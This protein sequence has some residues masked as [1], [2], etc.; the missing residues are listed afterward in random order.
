M[1]CSPAI[2]LKLESAL[3]PISFD[4]QRDILPDSSLLYPAYAKD[5]SSSCRLLPLRA[6][7]CF[8]QLQ[9][10]AGV[11]FQADGPP[12]TMTLSASWLQAPLLSGCCCLCAMSSSSKSPP[13]VSKCLVGD[14]CLH[15]FVLVATPLWNQLFRSGKTSNSSPVFYHFFLSSN[16]RLLSPSMPLIKALQRCDTFFSWLLILVFIVL[17]SHTPMSGTWSIYLFPFSHS[18]IQIYLPQDHSILVACLL[19]DCFLTRSS[20]ESW[21]QCVSEDLFSCSAASGCVALGNSVP[22]AVTQFP[23]W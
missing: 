21:S 8:W 4:S 9:L 7:P 16:S 10:L 14:G 20:N 22:F 18:N 12:Q 13:S 15:C 5:S 3:N 6:G 2:L 1:V 17:W 11:L 19:T 23:R